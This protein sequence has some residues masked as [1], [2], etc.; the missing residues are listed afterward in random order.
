MCHD[1]ALVQ[2]GGPAGYT[3]GTA[4]LAVIVRRRQEAI[5]LQGTLRAAP[6]VDGFLNRFARRPGA[7]LLVSSAARLIEIDWVDEL[8]V[9]SISYTP[10]GCGASKR[11]VPVAGQIAAQRVW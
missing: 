10:G 11:R 4:E 6:D 2:A 5:H 3:S 8:V 9:D 1:L 7:R